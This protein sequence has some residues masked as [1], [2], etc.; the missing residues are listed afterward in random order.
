MIV[1]LCGAVKNSESNRM[2]IVRNKKR[3][4]SKERAFVG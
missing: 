2:G 3:P 4:V 1:Q